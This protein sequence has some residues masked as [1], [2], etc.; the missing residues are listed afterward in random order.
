MAAYKEHCKIVQV[1]FNRHLMIT[2]VFVQILNNQVQYLST[3]QY[4]DEWSLMYMQE[5]GKA[6]I[7]QK[8]LKA[9]CGLNEM[10][11]WICS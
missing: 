1:Q 11:Q 6:D 3:G 10:Q 2:R 4:N 5:V 8:S 9:Q 7:I